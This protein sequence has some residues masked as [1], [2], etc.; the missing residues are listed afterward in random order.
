[1]L[2]RAKTRAHI[3]F[4]IIAIVTQNWDIRVSGTIVKSANVRVEEIA[5][6]A[7]GRQSETVT[8]RRIDFKKKKIKVDSYHAFLLFA[9]N[10]E[11]LSRH[12][13]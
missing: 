13:K 4:R 7:W 1:M 12:E 2:N 9:F 6:R 11:Q 5:L 3:S 10:L 8:R